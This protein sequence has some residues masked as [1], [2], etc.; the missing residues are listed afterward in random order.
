MYHHHDDDNDG[1]EDDDGCDY[2]DDCEN[3]MAMMVTHIHSPFFAHAL[4]LHMN[5]LKQTC[6][7]RRPSTRSFEASSV[8]NDLF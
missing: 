5:L 8:A 3:E 2:V 1:V 4:T 6:Y 7:S